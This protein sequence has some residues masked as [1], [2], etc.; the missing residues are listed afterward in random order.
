M[1]NNILYTNVITI[2]QYAVAVSIVVVIEIVAA[3]LAFVYADEAVSN[4]PTFMYIL[5]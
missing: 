5:L 1:Y 4:S 2:S 3:I